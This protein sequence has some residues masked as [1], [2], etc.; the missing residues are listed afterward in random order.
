MTPSSLHP[1]L[2]QS[3]QRLNQGVL[4]IRLRELK[5]LDGRLKHSVQGLEQGP[6]GL[7]SVTEGHQLAHGECCSHLRQPWDGVEWTKQAS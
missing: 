4:L 2:Y 1:N 5:H 6:V 7:L 3:Q